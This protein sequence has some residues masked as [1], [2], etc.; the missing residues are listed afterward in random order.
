MFAVQEFDAFEEVYNNGKPQTVYT[1]LVSDLETP[2]SVLLKLGADQPNCFLL[3][4]VEGN[5]ARGRYSILGM[6]PDLIWRAKGE[7]AEIARLPDLTAFQ[8]CD[9]PTLESFREL[10]EESRIELPVD[11]PPMAAGIVG[12]FSYDTVRLIEKLP[13]DNK[14]PA[15]PAGW[16]FHPPADHACI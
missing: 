9:K 14:D 5:V 6:D 10:L 13:D 8:E 7:R 4:S 2:V 1:S 12:Y 3:E 11:L 16:P 15:R